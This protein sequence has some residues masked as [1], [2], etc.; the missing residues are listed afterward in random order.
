MVLGKGAAPEYKYLVL[1]GELTP[2]QVNDAQGV[3]L[4]HR[5]MH[6][7]SPQPVHFLFHYICRLNS[8]FDTT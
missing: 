7:L 1:S 6:W 8:V 4:V 3:I 2:P 5:E